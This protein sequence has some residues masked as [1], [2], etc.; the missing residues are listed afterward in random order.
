MPTIV[1]LVQTILESSF[2][3]TNDAAFRAALYIFY[4]G[5]YVLSSAMFLLTL[6]VIK[7]DLRRLEKRLNE[8]SDVSNLLN[9]DAEQE[10]NDNTSINVINTTYKITDSNEQITYRNKAF[11]NNEI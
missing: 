8:T 10:E 2:N 1:P 9:A 7:F 6:F 4:P 11:E 3:L 5:E